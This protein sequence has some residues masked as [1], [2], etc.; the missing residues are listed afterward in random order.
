MP[1]GA[2]DRSDMEALF[3]SRFD[4]TPL[5][6]EM[7][8]YRASIGRFTIE[9]V[10]DAE[11]NAILRSGVSTSF[12]PFLGSSS[13]ESDVAIRVWFD[14]L[15]GIDRE[16]AEWLHHEFTAFSSAP[17]EEVSE[18]AQFGRLRA[19]F[20]TMYNGISGQHDWATWAV[21]VTPETEFSG[22]L[23][24]VDDGLLNVATAGQS[25]PLRWRLTHADG[26]PIV[27][28]DAVG[29]SVVE[30]PCGRPARTHPIEE[31]ATSA[32]PGLQNLG[33]GYYQ[34]NFAAPTAFANSCKTVRVDLREG[35]TLYPIYRTVDVQFL[36]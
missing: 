35:P 13:A 6:E 10:V 28:L 2:F 31:Y 29:V 15:S 26:S 20:R 7:L 11:T 8:L 24:P 18:E 22:F 16:A 3:R 12:D 14:F 9:F 33:D 23:P 5:V 1:L 25:I 17:G 34:Y 30:T 36:D 4:D 19:D 32:E 21:Q 27:D